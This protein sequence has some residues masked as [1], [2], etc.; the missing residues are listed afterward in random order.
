MIVELGNGWLLDN[1]W[2][3]VS[4]KPDLLVVL[5]IQQVY[6]GLEA[7]QHF[8]AQHF[9]VVIEVRN[10]F[11]RLSPQEVVDSREGQSDVEAEFLERHGLGVEHV[12]VGVLDELD[13]G[14]VVEVF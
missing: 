6:L 8:R 12:L 3:V 4:K 9:F 13:R 10:L 5:S 14:V 2:F 7:C 11:R 1:R